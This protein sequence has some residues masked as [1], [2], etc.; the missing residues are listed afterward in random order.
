M[1]R[2]QLFLDMDG[3]LADFDKRAAGIFDGMRP[4]KFEEAKGTREFWKRIHKHP[5]FFR[6]LEL[7]ED[8]RHLF[9]AVRHLNPTILT[10]IPS[11]K[12][13]AQ[14][15]MDWAA[16][17]FPGFRC[18]TCPAKKKSDYASPGDVLVDDRIKYKHL[19]EEVGGIYVVHTSA[20]NSIEQLKELGV[21]Y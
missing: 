17:H 3:V 18:I 13:S 4:E 7:M 15:K 14:Q 11:D 2:N 21:I 10:G 16:E 19:W 20:K 6:D 1:F 9:D 5:K 8:A 12:D